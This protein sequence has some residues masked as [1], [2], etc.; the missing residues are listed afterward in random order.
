MSSKIKELRT[1]PSHIINFIDII[2]HITPSKKTKY[3]ELLFKM[4]KNTDGFDLYTLEIKSWLINN[5]NIDKNFVEDLS[6]IQ[7]VLVYKFLDGLFNKEDI[8]AYQLFCDYNERNMVK[9][10]DITKI[11]SFTEIKKI[12]DIVK[13]LD[14]HKKF[15]KQVKNIFNDDEWLIIRPLTFESSLKYGANTK[16]CTAMKNES[17]Y[18][19]KYVS[20]GILIYTINKNNGLKVATHF[21]LS[22]NDLTFWNQ[23]DTR[24]DSLNSKLPLEIVLKIMNELN[25][26]P[27][28]N[29]DL[30]SIEQ[31]RKIDDGNQLKKLSDMRDLIHA[32]NPVP[33]AQENDYISNDVMMYG[34]ADV[35]TDSGNNF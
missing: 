25:N 2:T 9:N 18:F 4:I 10:N 28:S 15:E 34:G 13:I 20:N 31:K 23:E 21:E 29:Y 26:N 14:E 33:T 11:N 27:Q 7:L 12:V 5:Y 8:D 19:S 3:V 1:N 16:W 32:E 24:V 17:N 30:M 6:D 35:E 22:S